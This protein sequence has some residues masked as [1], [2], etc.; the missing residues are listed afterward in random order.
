MVVATVEKID[1]MVVATVEKIGWIFVVAFII[2]FLLTVIFYPS[3]APISPS[4][5]TK[6]YYYNLT[7]GSLM[8][9]NL[10]FTNG[11]Y[12]SGSYYAYIYDNYTINQ[13][14][15]ITPTRSINISAE[16]VKIKIDSMCSNSSGMNLM[17]IKE[18]GV[19]YSYKCN[20]R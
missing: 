4:P 14:K 7:N 20:E 9:L 10:T 19:A 11:S 1:N 2:F 16:Y 8:F 5:I 12:N 15:I 6:I 3:P 18:S 13:A 17:T